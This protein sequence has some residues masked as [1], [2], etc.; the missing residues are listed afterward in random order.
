MKKH[1]PYNQL[2]VDESIG[3]QPSTQYYELLEGSSENRDEHNINIDLMLDSLFMPLIELP[4]D[5][6][7]RMYQHTGHDMTEG[8]E[9]EPVEA[10]NRS[11][12]QTKQQKPS[13]CEQLRPEQNGY[14][15]HSQRYGT[16]N[17]NSSFDTRL[18]LERRKEPEDE[19]S[20]NCL[21]CPVQ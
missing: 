11:E 21:G 5:V 14:R 8:I 10:P 4:R 12:Q 16:F 19:Q 13:E 6:Y 20:Q 9:V 18:D 1:H 15:L 17:D 7:R 2:Q 3:S